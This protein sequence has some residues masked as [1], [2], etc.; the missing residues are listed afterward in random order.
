MNCMVISKNIQDFER[1]RIRSHDAGVVS[2][3]VPYAEVYLPEMQVALRSHKTESPN[4]L[5]FS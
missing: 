3:S 5:R 2:K 1:F 4:T